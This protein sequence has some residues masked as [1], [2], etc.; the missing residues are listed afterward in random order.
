M[1][2]NRKRRAF[3]PRVLEPPPAEDSR[4][5]TPER[6]RRARGFVE[7]G[8]LGKGRTGLVT[9]RDTPIERA[10][11]RG[12][13]SP[14]QYTAAIKYRHHWYHAGLASPLAS[15]ELDRIFAPDLTSYSGMPRT[16]AQVFHRQRY[17]EAVQH[18]GITGASVVEQVV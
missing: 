16:E 17:R 15:V 12:I 3:G 14:A 11:A 5:A 10:L 8:N 4:G 1:I 7:R 18:I 6:L 2:H 9:M 13:V